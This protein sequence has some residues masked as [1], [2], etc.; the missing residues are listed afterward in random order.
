MKSVV[1]L[2]GVMVLCIIVSPSSKGEDLELP[3][4]VERQKIG[5]SLY[6]VVQCPRPQKKYDDLLAKLGSIKEQIKKEACRQDQV[7]KIKEVETLE[8]LRRI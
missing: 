8:T 7:D 6:P 5:Y 4:D 1:K 3:I 2:L